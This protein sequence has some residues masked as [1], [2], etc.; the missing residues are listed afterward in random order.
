MDINFYTPKE[1]GELLKISERTIQR[2]LKN[3]EIKGNLIGKQWRVSEQDF[4]KFLD[5]TYNLQKK[6]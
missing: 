1:L 2:K 6:A 4:K 3:G 5:T